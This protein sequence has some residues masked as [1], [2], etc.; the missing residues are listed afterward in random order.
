MNTFSSSIPHAYAPGIRSRGCV[1]TEHREQAPA[2]P[3]KDRI[4]QQAKKLA[5]EMVR[6][7]IQVIKEAERKRW[8]LL[9]QKWG[10]AISALQADIQK[11]L[12]DMSIRV[13]EI[14]LQ[15][16]L[17]DRAMLRDVIEETL[18][19]ISDLQGMRI[20][21]AS[22]DVQFGQTGE[23]SPA[24]K[25]PIEWVCDSTLSPG[26]VVIESRNGI[27]DGRLRERLEVL[28]ETLSSPEKHL[29]T[30]STGTDKSK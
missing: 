14:I 26:D 5:G 1:V 2:I 8:E 9:E 21:L 30:N 27:F 4:E 23:L 28:R 11:H 13:A 25:G 3:D 24:R 20:R 22:G 18:A 10:K 6:Q 15:H 29:Q 7:E 16:Q 17:P 19:P 12:I